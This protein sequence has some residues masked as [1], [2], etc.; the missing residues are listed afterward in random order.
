MTLHKINDLGVGTWHLNAKDNEIN[1]SKVACN[2]LEYTQN[3]LNSRDVIETSC[4]ING[5]T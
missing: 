1:L 3:E 5:A 4:A 2:I